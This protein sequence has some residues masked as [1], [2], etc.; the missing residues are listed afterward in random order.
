M[1][2]K[3]QKKSKS[4][5]QATELRTMSVEEAAHVEAAWLASEECKQLRARQAELILDIAEK[6]GSYSRR[7]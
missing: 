1:V 6:S 3:R 5:D 4:F 2:I 7:A